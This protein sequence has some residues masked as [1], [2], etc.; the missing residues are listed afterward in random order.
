MVQLLE[1]R[2]AHQSARGINFLKILIDT[3]A[4]EKP[5]T[6]EGRYW[7]AVLPQLVTQL[8]GHRLYLLK[9]PGSLLQFDESPVIVLQAPA[10]D[11]QQPVIEDR[12]LAAL[13]TELEID[14]FLSTFNTTAGGRVRSI[15]VSPASV[16]NDSRAARLASAV[17]DNPTADAIIVALLDPPH[18]SQHEDEENALSLEAERLRKASLADAERLWAE[19][20]KPM[21]LMMRVLRGIKDVHRYPEYF[22]RIR[23]RV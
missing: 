19:A 21:P 5:E 14:V 3:L 22:K 15:L 4:L 17:L 23:Q 1:A 7:S 13:C 20:M 8:R 6:C 2:R 16:A 18:S 11:T 10:Y 12:R 9:R